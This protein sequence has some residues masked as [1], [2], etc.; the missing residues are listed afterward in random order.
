MA[1]ALD[2]AKQYYDS[3]SGDGSILGEILAEDLRFT[4]AMAQ[5]EN[6]AEF[7]ELLAGMGPM[8][9]GIKMYKQ[10]ENGEYISSFY[11]LRTSTPAGDVPMAELLRVRKGKIQEINLYYDA[12]AFADLPAP[13]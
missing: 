9:K 10:F 4:G 11:D 8:V 12:R 5:A 7:L 3:F 1:K 2:I 13:Q 6:R